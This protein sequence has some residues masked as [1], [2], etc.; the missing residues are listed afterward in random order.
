MAHVG[1]P[2]V[3]RNRRERP[4]GPG[5]VTTAGLLC[6]SCGTELGDK[7][8]FCHECAAP[9]LAAVTPAEYKQVTVLFADVVHSMDIAAAVAVVRRAL[10]VALLVGAAALFGAAGVAHADQDD[11]HSALIPAL[12]FPAGSSHP[13]PAADTPDSE[14]WHVPLGESDTIAYMRP[15]LPIGASMD[16]LPWCKRYYDDGRGGP[17]VAFRPGHPS[18]GFIWGN[19]QTGLSVIVT[20]GEVSGSD[21][22]IDRLAPEA[23]LPDTCGKS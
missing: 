4:R 18:T 19:T 12:T 5:V 9:V 11:L 7:A 17:N 20:S 16:G 21:V 6:G 15:M 2:A 13:A 23:G 10:A 3:T 14:I 8:K 1:W 22:F